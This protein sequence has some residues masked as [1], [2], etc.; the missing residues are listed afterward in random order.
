MEN[1]RFPTLPEMGTGESERAM[2]SEFRSRIYRIHR[3]F[4]IVIRC[5]VF[6]GMCEDTWESWD[7]E[8]GAGELRIEN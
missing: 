7:L 6:G 3:I 4:R 8:E 2:G 1:W 5:F